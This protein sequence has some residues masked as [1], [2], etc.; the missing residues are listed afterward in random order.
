MSRILKMNGIRKVFPG[1]VA[2]DNVDIS[3]EAGKVH[4]LLGE[5]GAGKSTLMKVLSGAYQPDAGTIELY[6]E[7]VKIDNVLDAKSL[8]ISIIYQE[9]SLSKNMT[10]AENIYALNEPVKFGLI[11]DDELNEKTK[12]LLSSLSIDIRPD[13]LVGELSIANQQMVEIA[14]AL[15]L[16]PK[17]VIMDEPTSALS[18]KETELLF[19]IIRKLK[20]EGK[21]IIYISHRME[22]IFEITDYVSVLRDGQ[23]IGTV[24]TEKTDVDELIDMMVGRKMEEFYPEKKFKYTDDRDLL[25]VVNY[26]KEGYY[27][28]IN[29]SVKPGEILG[30]YGLMGSGRT[31]II[32]GIFGILDKE[33]G[34]MYIDDN[35]VKVDSPKDA[36]D[37]GIAYVTENRKDEGLVLTA[38]LHEN[39]TIANL[40]GILGKHKLLDDKKEKRLA[41]DYV[42]SLGIKTPS[43]YQIVNKLSGG[44]QQKVVLS[45]WFEI[46]PKILILD[47]PTRGIDV[48]A[49]FQ[50][51]KL[52]LELAEKGVGIIMISSELPEV[53]NMSDRLLVVRN[54][55][56]IQ[57]LDSSKTNQEEIMKY[58]T[59]N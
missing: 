4:G 27:H 7:E 57:E 38:G 25:K 43:V 22:E 58:I 20:K 52:M 49:K 56:I 53:I 16:D 15:S 19:S 48:G 17:I 55:S 6:G 26:N 35:K 51:Y 21:S 45:K 18:S 31:E 2:L 8:G 29:L 28:D 36:I 24:E 40:D 50:I 30:I 37:N 9:L 46:N 54:N 33:S 12:K 39:M 3:L 13:V 10:V 11:D 41:K 14:K 47:E 32:Q 1:V 34:E 59:G 42:D 44:N 5:N 23:Y